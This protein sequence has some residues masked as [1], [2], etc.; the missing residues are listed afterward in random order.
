[1][2]P[3]W[4]IFFGCIAMMLFGWT[5]LLFYFWSYTKQQLRMAKADWNA[6]KYELRKAQRY[7][8][9]AKAYAEYGD[10][11]LA[12]AQETSAKTLAMLKNFEQ[13]IQEV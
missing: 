1:M 2:K 12:E 7:E 8:K 5:A 3:G 13:V 10:S 4:I 9:S 6:A 11:R